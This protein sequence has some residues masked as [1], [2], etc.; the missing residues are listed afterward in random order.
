MP[1]LSESRHGLQAELPTDP[2][3]AILPSDMLEYSARQTLKL[4]ARPGAWKG[5]LRQIGQQLRAGGTTIV[6]HLLQALRNAREVEIADLLEGLLADMGAPMAERI[7]RDLLDPTQPESYRDSL[8]QVY[9]HLSIDEGRKVQTLLRAL[10]D[11]DRHLRRIAVDALAAAELTS[12]A[13]LERLAEMVER[14]QDEAVREAA[15]RALDEL[16]R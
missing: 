6:P 16:R 14:D 9:C 11:P 3:G 13:I 15:R 4:L 1:L 10:K 2:E 7:E 5:R 8:L 12:R